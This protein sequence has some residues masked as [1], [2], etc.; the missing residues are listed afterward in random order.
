MK[1]DFPGLALFT[2]VEDAA[3][4]VWLVLA[5]SN[6]A[7]FG[8]L[9]LIVGFFIEHVIAYNVKRRQ[10][11]FSFNQ[12]P[13]GKVFLNALLETFLVWVPWLV[14]WDIHPALA[15]VYVYPTLV[16]EHSFTDNIFHNRSLVAN[17]FNRKVWGFS[18]LEGTGCNGWL[19]L[20]TYGQPVLGVIV[21][22]VFQFLEHR[23][24]INLGRVPAPVS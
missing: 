6:R 2:I 3:L 14:L 7:V 8:I 9:T 10:S 11:L 15:I 22:V 16:V 21:L 12:L 13:A 20:V 5:R 19:A 1:S 4:V 24:A 17:L 18:F 23:M